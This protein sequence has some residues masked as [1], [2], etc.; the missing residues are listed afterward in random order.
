MGQIGTGPGRVPIFCLPL[1]YSYSSVPV[2]A[3]TA[4][5]RL[6][7]PRAHLSPGF[8]NGARADKF[9]IIFLLLFAPFRGCSVFLHAFEFWFILSNFRNFTIRI[10]IKIY[11]RFWGL[12]FI[13]NNN[14]NR[15]FMV[16]KNVSD[17]HSIIMPKSEK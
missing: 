5:I 15:R 13:S 11:I 6:L 4:S 17:K 1:S 14:N 7:H 3:Q 9:P 10:Y 2:H 16:I 12:F 8:E